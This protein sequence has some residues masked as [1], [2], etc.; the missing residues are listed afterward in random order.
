M[1]RLSAQHFRFSVFK[2]AAFFLAQVRDLPK[3]FRAD[4]HKWIQRVFQLV[5]AQLGIR[6]NLSGWLATT[7]LCMAVL[8][9]LS[10]NPQQDMLSWIQTR[11]IYVH[12]SVVL[13]WKGKKENL[14]N[15][16]PV[17]F[18]SLPGTV[19]EHIPLEAISKCEG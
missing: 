8:A 11:Q 15:Y 9:L 1:R 5:P 3:C 10:L 2:Y 18:P 17:N 12:G 16:R 14:G 7:C 4:L 6:N 19:M 13:S